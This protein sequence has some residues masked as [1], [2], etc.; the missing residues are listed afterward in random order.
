[1]PTP[2]I[3][4]DDTEAEVGF[5]ELVNF[6]KDMSE[7]PQDAMST[8]PSIAKAEFGAALRKDKQQY[9][10]YVE[11][12][13]VS[14]I[15]HVSNEAYSPNQCQPTSPFCCRQCRQGISGPYRYS[16]NQCRIDYCSQCFHESNVILHNHPLRPSPINTIIQR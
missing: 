13:R 14:P 9:P 11:Q 5:E 8:K 16:C 6:L 12:S 7:E 4:L 1:M 15:P 10:M 2:R 3:A